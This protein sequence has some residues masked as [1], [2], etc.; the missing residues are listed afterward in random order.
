MTAIGVIIL[1][2]QI[3]PMMG[4]SVSQ[5]VEY[6]NRFIPVAEAQLMEKILEEESKEGILVLEDFQETLRRAE[7][8]EA[9]AI[10]E[11]AVFLASKQS[12][13]VVGTLRILPRILDQLLWMELLL[14]LLTV[15][16]IYGVKRFNKSFP[17]TLIALLVVTLGAVVTGIPYRPIQ[18]IP[19][20]F[21]TFQVAIFNDFDFWELVPYLAA[22]LTLSLLGAIDSLLTSIVADNLT[23]TRHRPNQELIG[24]GIGNSISA[25]FGGIPGAGATVRTV[26]NIQSGGKTKLSGMAAALV[27]LA[28]L[29]LFGPVASQIPAAVLAGILITVGIGVMDYRGLKSLKKFPAL[30]YS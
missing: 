29:L 1:I 26:V 23:K 27:L 15:G 14:T 3:Q 16:I 30:R 10:H 6:I 7:K 18:Q 12:S 13:G 21:P 24:Q 11:E 2:T 17:G 5:D 9:T 25:L 20:G 28:I 22:A 19:E 8:I 4:Y